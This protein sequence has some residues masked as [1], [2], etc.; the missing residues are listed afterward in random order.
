VLLDVLFLAC[1]L[2][3]VIAVGLERSGLVGEGEVVAGLGGLTRLITGLVWLA[4]TLALLHHSG[5]T[6]GKHLL[7]IRIGRKSGAR[8]SL[9]RLI[10][11]GL[12]VSGVLLALPYAGKM[13]FLLDSA[14]IMGKSRQ[15]L[16]DRIADTVVVTS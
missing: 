3:S 1:V 4:G 2:P 10:L 14:L 13:C 15:C 6:P 16:R 11:L 9:P 7:G 8:T 12:L 5:Q